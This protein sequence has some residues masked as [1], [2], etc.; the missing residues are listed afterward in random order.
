MIS[1]RMLMTS[2]A[3]LYPEEGRTLWIGPPFFA[4]CGHA[5]P[6]NGECSGLI[7]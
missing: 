2:N 6:D 7:V 4:L 3:S 1:V 5:M